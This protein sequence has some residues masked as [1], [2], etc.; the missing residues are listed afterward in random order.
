MGKEIFIVINIEMMIY[1]I[2]LVGFCIFIVSFIYTLNKNLRLINRFKNMVKNQW[3]LFKRSI[4]RF[5]AD[6]S[7][8]PYFIGLF[9]A[10]FLDISWYDVMNV[11]VALI[12]LD[13]CG[14]ISLENKK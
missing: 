2:L 11:L 12:L 8:I 4:K 14:I 5:L 10:S 3:F 1:I 13:Y 6:E 9:L 7:F